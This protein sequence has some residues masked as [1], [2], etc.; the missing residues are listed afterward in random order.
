ME[1]SSL[2]AFA[3]VSVLLVLVPGADWAYA[4]AAGLRQRSVVPAVSGLMLGYVA[5]TCVVAAGLAA[6]IAARPELLTALTVAG[7][8]YLLWLGVGTA[9]HPTQPA[10]ADSVERSSG[11]VFFKGAGI[12]GLNPKGMLLFLALMP[13]FLRGNWPIA[14]QIG[15][16]GLIHI[17]ICGVVYSG[18]ATTARALLRTRP[19]I[20]HQVARG[21]GITMIL[22]AAGL[23]LERLH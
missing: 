16:L 4:I 23:L 13:Q 10:S 11:R 6:L 19:T 7:A 5:L 8:A 20:A 22:I 21:S 14:A 17:I 1:I 9:L 2:A 18:V 12:S 15:A 3:T